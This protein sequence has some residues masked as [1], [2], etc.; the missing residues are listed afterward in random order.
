MYTIIMNNNKSLTTSKRIALYEGDNLAD[1]IRF[2]F[3][4]TYKDISLADCIVVLKY[5]DVTGQEQTEVLVKEDDLY[6]NRLSYKYPVDS[7]FTRFYGDI[8]YYIS[9]LMFNEDE[10]TEDVLFHTES[11]TITINP[12]PD[13]IAPDETIP[14]DSASKILK[15]V[16]YLEERVEE[17]EE[18]GAGAKNVVKYVDQNLSSDQQEQ[19]RKNIG[20]ISIDEVPKVEIPEQVQADYAQTDSTKPDY[21]K[22]K[23]TDLVKNID[24]AT[25]NKVG[26]VRT[27]ALYGTSMNGEYIMISPA[28]LSEI[29]SKSNTYKPITPETIDYAVRSGL[30]DSSLIWNDSQK[31]KAREVIGALSVD[32]IPNNIP[33]VTTAS[34]GQIL[35]VEEIDEDGKPIKWKASD[36]SE[37]IEI[38]LSEYV[39]NTDYATS[40][41]AGIVTVPSAFGVQIYNGGLRINAATNSD[42]DSKNSSKPITPSNLDYAIKS[43]LTTNTLEWT[44]EEKKAAREL[45]G[46]GTGSGGG[47]EGTVV[48]SVEQTTTSTESGGKNIVTVTKTDGSTNE[49][50]ILNGVDGLTP[51]IDEEGYISYSDSES[52]KGLVEITEGRPTK[53]GTVL[54]VD[55]KAEEVRLY[56]ADEIDVMMQNIPSGGSVGKFIGEV[57]IDNDETRLVEWT[58]CADGSPLDFDELFIMC[59]G[60][61]DSTRNLC[62]TVNNEYSCSNY[63][64][65]AESS[66]SLVADKVWYMTSHF[67]MIGGQWIELGY[68][69]QTTIYSTNVLRPYNSVKKGTQ[70]CT[71]SLVVGIGWGHFI[72][73]SKI[74]VYGR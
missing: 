57:T 67:R 19:A 4:Q 35:E 73:G 70:R 33:K 31:K 15:E 6:K 10:N 51:H 54:T 18:N 11:H 64:W 68:T 66:A 42:V 45:I 17:L 36:K 22:N 46:A 56:T 52:V 63:D 62:F 12:R 50:E 58:E 34:V 23:P 1:K 40:T 27:N 48:E 28:S 44:D 61:A 47:F 30:T 9:F 21:I 72:N 26:L 74:A 53:K 20:A 69:K 71:A 7:K 3:P 55:P 13:S 5:I 32:E 25:E 60:M 14:E 37:G 43:G 29:D 16:Y 59:E 49:V 8:L 24:Y 2:L 41:K 38:D 39:K 65:S